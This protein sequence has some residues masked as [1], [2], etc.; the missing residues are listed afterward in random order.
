[1]KTGLHQLE[2][3]DHIIYSDNWNDLVVRKILAVLPTDNPEEPLFCVSMGCHW[4][5]KDDIDPDELNELAKAGVQMTTAELK[6]K[7]YQIFDME[8]ETVIVSP[9]NIIKSLSERYDG[10]QIHVVD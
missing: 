6:A 2:A 7:P 3:G 1:M 10:L 9:D 5:P 8:T 4:T